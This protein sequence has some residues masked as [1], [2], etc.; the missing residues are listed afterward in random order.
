MWA[1][2][3]QGGGQG[4]GALKQGSSSSQE[5][6]YTL[7]RTPGQELV[8]QTWEVIGA[9]CDLG[10]MENG[11]TCLEKKKNTRE[12]PDYEWKRETERTELLEEGP[13]CRPGG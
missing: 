12:G 9:S 10:T 3:S 1:D 5:A 6:I 4:K 2:V 11:E 13:G 8:F 7:L